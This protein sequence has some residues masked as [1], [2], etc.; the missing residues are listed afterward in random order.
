MLKR[1]AVVS[2]VWI[3]ILVLFSAALAPGMSGMFD[4][5]SRQ[6]FAQTFN[7]PVMIAMMGP[8][9]GADH[10]TQG[11]MYSNMM[12]LWILIAVA[13]MNIFLVSRHTRADEEKGRAELARSLP[14][15]RLALLN[16]AM[17]TA[18]IVNAALGILMGLGIGATG[19]E[20]MGMGGSMLYGAVVFATGLVFASI[21]AV[22]CQLTSGRSGA[23]GYAFAAMGLFYMVRAAGDMAGGGFLSCISPL[24]LAQRAQVY[25]QNRLWPVF[26]LLLESAVIAAAAYK[27]NE[28]RDL[29]QGLIPARPGRKDASVY[30]R[31]PFG[32]ALR[33]L[34]NT[35]IIWIAAMF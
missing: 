4:T 9:Y 12:L 24:G 16:A 25:V 11:A 1:E 17:I 2:T 35:L 21:T 8:V 30:L 14:T 29:G 34:R 26:A 10:Y 22:F 19:V 33:L 31:S 15:G 13:V 7:N 3:L 5:D 20:T 32:L 18:F 28:I 6:Q 23:T 27:L